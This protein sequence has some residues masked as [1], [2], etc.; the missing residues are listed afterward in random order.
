MSQPPLF[1]DFLMM[2]KKGASTIYGLKKTY[3]RGFTLI[4]LMIGMVIGLLSTLAI[5]K[6]LL[7][8]EGQKRSTTSGAEAQT[9]GLLA[10]ESLRQIVQISGYGFANARSSIGCTLEAKFNGAAVANFPAKL[11]P[12]VIVDGAAGA[13]DSIRA[14]ASSKTSYS[15]PISIVD[16]GYVA[17]DNTKNKS[18]PVAASF[19]VADKDLLLA[20]IDSTSKCQIFQST[21]TPT[22]DVIPRD[23]DV[24]QWNPTNYPDQNYGFGQ[25]LVN[26]GSFDDTTL[27]VSAQGALQFN[28]FALA[29]NVTPSYTGATDLFADIVNMQAYYGKDTDGNGVVDTW[30]VVT[31]TTN[32]GWLEVMALRVALVSRST[33]YEKDAV[34]TAA[35]LWDVGANSAITDAAA[36]GTSKCIGLI[37]PHPLSSTDW[38]HYRYK[39]FD[40]IIPLRNMIWR[41]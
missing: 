23:D 41:Q 31:P 38:Q 29:N 28:K 5:T 13:P 25:Y 16:P 3:V 24:S 12:V 19:G 30:N 35:P 2:S 15:I 6:I 33:Q 1:V 34:T 36:C 27:M 20:V 8:S 17:A 21:S 39:V 18:F 14:L 9:N 10:L 7:I 32:A 40:T 22:G 26:L 11:E 4:E 37:V